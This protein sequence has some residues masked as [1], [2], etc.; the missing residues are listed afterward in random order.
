[1]LSLIKVK[2][3]SAYGTERYYPA[4]NSAEL[5]IVKLLR[6]EC[7]SENQIAILETLGWKVEVVKAE[8][9]NL[10][11]DAGLGASGPGFKK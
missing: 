7:L 10:D 4:N 1:M 3:K 2:A 6:Q 11:P 5:L 9:S 8:E